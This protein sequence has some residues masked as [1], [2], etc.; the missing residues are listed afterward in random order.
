MKLKQVADIQTGYLFRTKVPEDPNGNVVV[1]QMKDCS[2]I[3][4]IDWEHCVKTRLEQVREHEWL[5]EGDIL[6]PSR[7]NNYQAVYIDG[8]ITDRKAV[9]SPHFFVIRVASPQIL[10][11]YLYWWLNL[12]ASQKYLNQNIEGSITKSIRRPIL[13][14]LPIKLPPLSNQAM[15][16]SIAETAEQERLIA[17]RLIENSKRLMNALS[18]YLD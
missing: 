11:K 4:G 8:R 5:R 15:I 13:Q 18:Q 1:V 2:A 3:N 10:P 12:Q 9:A 7:G 14:A 6:I 17:L 16:I